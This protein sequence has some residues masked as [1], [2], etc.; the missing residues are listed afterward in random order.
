VIVENA[1]REI[2]SILNENL[3]VAAKALDLYNEFLFL[4]KEGE[5]FEEFLE[6]KEYKREIFEANINKYMATIDKIKRTCP[7]EIRLNMFLIQ[8][9][10]L[11]NKL[12][13][14]CEDLI[15][16]NVDAVS[17]YV[18]NQE[19]VNVKTA[20]QNIIT[21][22]QKGPKTTQE[23]VLADNYFKEVEGTE[24]QKIQQKYE[25]LVEWLMF[26]QM[27]P[28]PKCKQDN[29][30]KDEEINHIKSTYTIYMKLATAIDNQT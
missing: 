24:R 6:K 9:E 7:F 4:M 29:T 1:K 20:V 15:E 19:S 12:V 3:E 21:E 5:K 28:Q 10:E 25:Q 22:F 30:H 16:K 27:L 11:N 23:L 26:L 2:T 18:F 14:L 8:T 17:D 13:E